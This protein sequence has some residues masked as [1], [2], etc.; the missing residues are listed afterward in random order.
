MHA[1][2]LVDFG[3]G[4]L[5]S[6]ERALLQ[7]AGDAGAP[8]AVTRTRDPE[9]IA[10]ADKVVVPGQGAFR[11]C[12]AALQAGIGDALRA[13]IRKGTPYLGICLGMQ[14]LF[15]ASEEAEG[16]RGLGVFPGIVERLTPEPPAA[17]AESSAAAAG[18]W[19]GIKIPHMGWNRIT[20]TREASGPLRVFS[21]ESPYVYF[22]HSYHAVPSEP[23]LVAATTEHGPH[24]I[25]AAIERDNVTA[26]QFHPEKSQETG[27]RL[28][29]RF[30]A[31]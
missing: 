28:L 20:L 7:A 21:G 10:R 6:V 24:R 29:A 17:A 30:L 3:M 25:T 5:R 1:I 19:V 27:L 4:N 13:Q 2:A 18:P 22:V 23:A 26:T 31:G 8:C 12:A 14:A 11:D 16:A 9:V 15:D